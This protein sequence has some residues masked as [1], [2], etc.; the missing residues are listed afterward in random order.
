MRGSLYSTCAAAIV[1]VIV[2][3]ANQSQLKCMTSSSIRIN[4]TDM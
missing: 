3:F 4:K 1:A 2:V